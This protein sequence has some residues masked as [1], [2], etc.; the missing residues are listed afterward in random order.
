MI[1]DI[2]LYYY[3]NPESDIFLAAKNKNGVLFAG[4]LLEQVTGATQMGMW[5]IHLTWKLG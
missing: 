1:I 5:F 4:I 2:L 3:I